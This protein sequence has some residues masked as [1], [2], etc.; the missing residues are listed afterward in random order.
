M[1]GTIN[2]ATITLKKTDTLKSIYIA[3]FC[4]LT[5]SA[6][7]QT[8]QLPTTINGGY[9]QFGNNN[10]QYIYPE[11]RL[12]EGMVI[13]LDKFISKMQIDS[14][15]YHIKNFKVNT[16]MTSNGAA[17]KAD[18]IKYFKSKGLKYIGSEREIIV[19]DAI[20]ENIEV[21]LIKKDSCLT[22]LIGIL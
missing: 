12:T 19:R 16:A 13:E 11:V 6:F 10:N 8:R 21:G 4:I 17:L 2:L 18:M 3:I 9:N 15:F 7:A 14:N 5:I 20:V 22:I 1:G